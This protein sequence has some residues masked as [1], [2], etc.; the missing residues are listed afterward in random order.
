MP[1]NGFQD[2][3]P[4]PKDII[5]FHKKIG[6]IDP[7][8]EC[9]P[10]TAYIDK[11]GYGQFKWRKRAWWAHRWSYMLYVGPIPDEMTIHH[12]RESI[13]C[14][15]GPFRDET[16]S[17]TQ[18]NEKNPKRAIYPILK[19]YTYPFSGDTPVIDHI[20]DIGMVTVGPELYLD[21]ADITN[22]DTPTL[23]AVYCMGNAGPDVYV[24]DGERW[25]KAVRQPNGYQLVQTNIRLSPADLGA[26]KAA[27]GDMKFNGFIA[28]VSMIDTMIDQAAKSHAL[29]QSI[30]KH[31][32][33]GL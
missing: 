9:W 3:A 25:G 19:W 32:H 18:Q 33:G 8:S 11:K 1:L 17:G 7:E 2:Q 6:T 26:M 13:M 5:R 23:C 10:W 4:T 29:A 27:S 21:T 15:S 20:F 31:L 22:P 14:E 24:T 12:T 28:K 30:S 16:D